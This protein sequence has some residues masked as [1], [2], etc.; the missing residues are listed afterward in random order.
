[1]KKKEF[2]E[3]YVGKKVAVHC[4]TKSSAE[5][6][7]GLAEDFG[8][9]ALGFL[10]NWKCYREDTVYILNIDA[11]A[12]VDFA[13]REGYN[14]I[15]FESIK[16]NI[17][18]REFSHDFERRHMDAVCC[19]G[20]ADLDK[21]ERKDSELHMFCDYLHDSTNNDVERYRI[22]ATSKIGRYEVEYLRGRIRGGSLGISWY[23]FSIEE[24]ESNGWIQIDNNYK[25]ID[26]S[27]SVYPAK[28]LMNGW[29]KK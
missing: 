19:K 1:M 16:T 29:H 24:T 8:H 22:V 5:E 7:L 6:F 28:V 12:S 4:P 23:Y 3:K 21:K 26:H 18:K 20:V 10:Y 13:T 27:L 15:E 11:Y 14:V 25:I 9:N 2:E 17:N